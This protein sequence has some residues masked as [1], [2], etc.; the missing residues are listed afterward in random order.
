MWAFQ[1]VKIC[2]THYMFARDFLF[3][4]C[5]TIDM[6]AGVPVTVCRCL[7]CFIF[8]LLPASSKKL[9]KVNRISGPHLW[10]NLP[11]DYVILN[12][13]PRHTV[14]HYRPCRSS[15]WCH[16]V[17]RHWQL[18]MMGRVAR[19]PTRDRQCRLD[20]TTFAAPSYT[21]THLFS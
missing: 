18:T 11:F 8:H 7:T 15:F 13:G 10:N 5:I 4:I 21:N 19:V 2:P 9:A 16:F 1:W 3:T 20:K 14:C 6:P 17:G 12:V